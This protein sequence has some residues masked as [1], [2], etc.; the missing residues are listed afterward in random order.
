[1]PDLV[2]PSLVILTSGHSDTQ[3][4]TSLSGC[5]KLQMTA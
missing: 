5:Q 3:P 2:E 4:W 1:M